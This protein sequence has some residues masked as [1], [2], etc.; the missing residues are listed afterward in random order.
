MCLGVF[1]LV[2]VSKRENYGQI[3]V[4]AVHLPVVCGRA[5][6]MCPLTSMPDDQVQLSRLVLIESISESLQLDHCNTENSLYNEGIGSIAGG[7]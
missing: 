7:R 6:Q 4:P 5:L 3:I 1:D 2:T